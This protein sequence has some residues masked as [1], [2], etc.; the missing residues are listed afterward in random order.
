MIKPSQITTTATLDVAPYM[1]QYTVYNPTTSAAN[2]RLS[3]SVDKGQTWQT[4]VESVITVDAGSTKTATAQLPTDARI[5]LRINQ[6]SGSAKAKCYLDDIKLFYTETWEPEVII[7]D[8][9]GDSEVGISD[10]NAVID[11]ILGARGNDELRARADVN[12][13]GEI[14][15]SDVNMIID[16]I[17]K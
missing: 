12:G 17:L 14:S 4:A 8:V 15:I 7:G 10:V 3:Y 16:L 1:V 6:T 2:F 5:M 11:L 9:D 13:D